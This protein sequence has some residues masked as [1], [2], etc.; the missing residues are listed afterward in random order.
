MTKFLP[1]KLLYSMSPNYSFGVILPQ[2][3]FLSNDFMLLFLFKGEKKF[4][5][6]TSFIA[7]RK[8]SSTRTL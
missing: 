3:L 1:D 4:L 5:N 6:V 8:Y 2:M 7:K